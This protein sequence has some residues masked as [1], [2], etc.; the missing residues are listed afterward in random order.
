M[1]YLISINTV[2]SVRGYRYVQN[3]CVL[4]SIML[5]V[6]IEINKYFYNTNDINCSERKLKYVVRS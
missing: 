4:P 3:S 1:N 6:E 5:L 2:P